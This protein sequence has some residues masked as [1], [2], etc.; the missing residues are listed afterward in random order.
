LLRA[1]ETVLTCSNNIQA[2]EDYEVSGYVDQLGPLLDTPLWDMPPPAGYYALP[3]ATPLR[4]PSHIPYRTVDKRSRNY[5]YLFRLISLNVLRLDVWLTSQ[6]RQS[7][8]L[9]LQS[10][11]LGLPHPLTRR[12]VCT[13]PPFWF[14]GAHLLTGEGAKESRFGRGDRHCGTLGLYVPCG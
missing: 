7:A 8:K 6:S 1:L 14:R 10:S 9:L 4:R 2:G 12:R 11:E 13:P 5:F 3:L